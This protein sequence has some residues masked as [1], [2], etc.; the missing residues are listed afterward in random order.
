MLSSRERI[1]LE[2]RFARELERLLGD[3]DAV[4]D[5]LHAAL[6]ARSVEADALRWKEAVGQA[7][8]LMREYTPLRSLEFR[9]RL[10]EASTKGTGT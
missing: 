2:V 1:E 5:A 3:A 7:E 6:L 8:A 4:T 10:D 9:V